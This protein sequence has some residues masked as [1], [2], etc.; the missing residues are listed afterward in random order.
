MATAFT[1]KPQTLVR[2][3]GNMFA[4]ALDGLRRTWDI[5]QW[6]REYISQCWFIAKVT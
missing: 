3:T 5:R 2:E 1:Q 4:V 6:W